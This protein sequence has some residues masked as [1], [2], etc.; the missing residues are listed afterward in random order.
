VT[1]RGRTPK[2]SLGDR[3]LT[4][5]RR[6]IERTCEHPGD[7]PGTRADRAGSPV[8]VV[9]R[10]ST[11]NLSGAAYRWWASRCAGAQVPML[12]PAQDCELPAGN[13]SRRP[14]DTP[15]VRTAMLGDARWERRG[16]VSGDR[17]EPPP[18]LPRVTPGARRQVPLPAGTGRTIASGRASPARPATC[19]SGAAAPSQWHAAR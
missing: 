2:S 14:P 18:R 19:A 15:M 11:S 7:L 13:Y 8:C 16:W 17:T 1:A 5:R 3:S 10:R 12:G 9:V 6:G 4:E